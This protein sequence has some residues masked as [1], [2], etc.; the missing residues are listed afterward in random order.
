MGP[1]DAED[2]PDLRRSFRDPEGHTIRHGGRVLRRVARP[3]Q[4][5]RLLAS[6]LWA[7][8]LGRGTVPATSEVADGLFEHQP[9]PFPSYPPE[10]TPGM[11]AEAGRLTLDLAARALDAGHVLKDASPHNIL[12]RGPD[13]VLV[14]VLSFAPAE[15]DIGAWPPA[16]QFVRCFLIPL[17]MHR[18]LGLPMRHLMSRRDGIEPAQ[19]AAALGIR[20]WKPGALSTVAIPALLDPAADQRGETLYEPRRVADPEQALWMARRQIAALGRKLDKLDPGPTRSTWTGY[21]GAGAEAKLDFVGEVVAA[22]RPGWVLDLGC[23]LGQFSF[24]AA[25]AGSHVV[26][27]DADQACVDAVWRKA[28]AT[29]ADVLPLV[30]DLASPTPAGGWRHRETLS[31]EERA[32][33]RFDLVLALALVHHLAVTERV[34][35]VEIVATLADW[36]RSLAVVEFVGPDDPQFRRLLRGRAHLHADYTQAGFERALESRFVVLR[37]SALEIDHNAGFDR[38]LYLLSLRKPPL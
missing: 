17:L 19:A 27:A 7:E 30:V 14:D 24:L 11:L 34:P 15:P 31:W 18:E 38:T 1:Q 20:R 26:A 37:R 22:H 12:F 32:A 23:N 9:V 8:L 13:P 25:G 6:S 4:L 35:L 5:R 33:G 29:R 36:T 2:R 10:W 28:R 16:S 21:D 3:D